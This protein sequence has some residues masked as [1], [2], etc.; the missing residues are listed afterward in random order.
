M[1]RCPGCRARLAEGP[2]CQRCGCDLTLVRR[3]ETQACRLVRRAL[4]AWLE[5]NRQQA[6]ALATASLALENSRLGRLVLK[7]VS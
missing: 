3:A 4:R 6:K 5:G 1:E 2:A 7:C